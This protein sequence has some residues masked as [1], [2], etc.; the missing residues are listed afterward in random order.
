MIKWLSVKQSSYD[1]LSK[2]FFLNLEENKISQPAE[3]ENEVI[4]NLEIHT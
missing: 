1:T 4:T 3:I 2:V